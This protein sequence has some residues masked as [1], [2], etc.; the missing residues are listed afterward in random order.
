MLP[1]VWMFWI[2]LYPLTAAI[3]FMAGTLSAPL[4]FRL[5]SLHRDE[6]NVAAGFGIIIG[7]AVIVVFSR[8]E[9]RLAQNVAYRAVR[10][11]VRLLLFGALAL[12]WIQAMVFDVAGG[13]ETRYI[14]T[15]LGHPAYLMIQLAKPQN[16]AIVGVVMGGMHFLLWK[17][18]RLRA[19]WHRR[20][21]WIGLK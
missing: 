18:E 5:L 16:L 21:T 20:L 6:I 10:H 12:P 4:A 15:V 19:F 2:C 17:A 11:G 3:G 14:L 13:S 1:F 7:Y 8:I 9:Y